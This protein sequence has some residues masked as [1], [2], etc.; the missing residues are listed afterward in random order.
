MNHQEVLDSVCLRTAV[1]GISSVDPL[2]QPRTVAGS[3][4]EPIARPDGASTR[5]DRS[6]KV[7][8]IGRDPCGFT[9]ETESLLRDRLRSFSFITAVIF[10]ITFAFSMYAG[11][12]YPTSRAI[13]LAVVIGCALWM[14]IGSVTTLWQLRVVELVLFG[15][16]AAI[17]HLAA[18]GQMLRYAEDGDRVAT[19]VWK[20]QF[21]GSF[22]ALLL[23]YAMFIPNTWR[24]AAS[25]LLP[26][27]CLPYLMFLI[28]RETHPNLTAFLDADR[29]VFTL[30]VPVFSTLIGIYGSHALQRVRR[31][32][33][34]ARQFGQYVLKEQIGT[35]G[36]GEI[37]RAEHLLLKRP[38]AIKLIRPER[39][40]DEATLNR[41]EIEVRATARLT[42]LNTVEIYDY[43][44][45]TDGTFYYVMEL[46]RGLDL[47]D[48]VRQHGPIAPERAVH[49]LR[50]VSG[51]LR[52]AHSTGL[53]HR[54]IKPGNIFASERGGVYDVAK[55]LDFGLVKQ[56]TQDENEE[57]PRPRKFS[58]TLLYM[59]PE[60]ASHYDD[61]DPRSDI[62][63][64][65]AVAFFLLTGQ[66]P[67]VRKE[68]AE[69]LRAHAFEEAQAPSLIRPEI[70]ADL[71]AV[72]L[73]C[74]RKRPVDRFPDAASLEQ[75][76]AACLCSD[77]WN[78]RRAAEWWQSLATRE[79]ATPAILTPQTW[80]LP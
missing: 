57:G 40:A 43:G 2:E 56:K 31:D 7:A 9:Q 62:Y 23:T 78:D 61:A 49:L 77:D 45:A 35:G 64:L 39:D 32:A 8:L 74:L 46:L 36:M 22:T 29:S 5:P 33:F 63:A 15:T 28:L 20:R 48:L 17:L 58:G 44:R 34:E 69:I 41:F 30:P 38:C 26:A 10:C 50:Q 24:R 19:L 67:F 14:R 75:A 59:A 25:I 16:L 13:L 73:R 80:T 54:D 70:P 21:L 3:L 51:A 52:E 72:V 1:T 53:V 11:F 55:L 6:A 37:Y 79:A 27:V 66:P 60:Q 68:N 47:E 65:G 18:A 76:L 42:H 4:P 12:P 71:D